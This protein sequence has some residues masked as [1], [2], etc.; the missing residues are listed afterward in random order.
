[1]KALIEATPY[2]RFVRVYLRGGQTL[3]GHLQGLLLLKGVT[4]GQ[5]WAVQ[6]WEPAATGRGVVHR[7]T[8]WLNDIAGYD[9]GSEA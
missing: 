8:A 1:M 9:S 4:G 3:M 7:H 2:G 5:Q 6:L